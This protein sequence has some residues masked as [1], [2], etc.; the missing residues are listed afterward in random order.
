MWNKMLEDPIRSQNVTQ[1]YHKM[2][3]THT[4]THTQHTHSVRSH[5]KII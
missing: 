4:H 3:N 1:I 2:W 5:F